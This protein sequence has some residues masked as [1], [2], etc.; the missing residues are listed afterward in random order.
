[1]KTITKPSLLDNLGGLLKVWAVPPSVVTLTGKTL[2]VSSST[3]VIQLYCTEDS[4][5]FKCE[6]KQK[7][8]NAYYDVS[9]SGATFCK[10]AAD[11]VILEE[12]EQ[13]RWV[14]V[15]EDGNGVF[16]L[17]GT[18]T[19]RF[20][21]FTQEETGKATS[22]RNQVSFEFSGET[23]KRPFIITDPF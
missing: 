5:S 2:A 20:R 18:P 9:I 17:A 21:F 11:E 4:A 8:G 13:K 22:D 14:I 1:M 12:L 16:K 19:E 6:I 23:T 3:D 7:N 10:T 15:F